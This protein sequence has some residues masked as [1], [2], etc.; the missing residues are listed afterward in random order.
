LLGHLIQAGGTGLTQASS[1]EWWLEPDAIPE[2]FGATHL[3][4]SGLKVAPL[5]TRDFVLSFLSP[6]LPATHSAEAGWGL[7]LRLAL[8]LTASKAEAWGLDSTAIQHCNE[9][10]LSLPVQFGNSG[11]HQ[12][13]LVA[14]VREMEEQPLAV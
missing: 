7:L 1:H 14:L 12:L 4:S 2:G 6:D 8:Q 5:P 13:L 10:L 3:R 11:N 9:L